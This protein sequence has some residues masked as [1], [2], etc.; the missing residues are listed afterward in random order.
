[1][2]SHDWTNLASCGPPLTRAVS[3]A[4]RLY[5]TLFLSDLGP[6]SGAV[7]LLEKTEAAPALQPRSVH[8]VLPVEVKAQAQSAAKTFGGRRV[9]AG[10]GDCTRCLHPWPGARLKQSG[11]PGSAP[12]QLGEPGSST[13]FCNQ[14]GSFKVLKNHMDIILSTVPGQTSLQCQTWPGQQQ[15][16][17]CWTNSKYY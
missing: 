10:A 16:T 2:S 15:P 3:T 12:W 17:V 7:R 13:C 11:G 6:G 14:Y 9:T 8:G 1:M 4:W 5:S